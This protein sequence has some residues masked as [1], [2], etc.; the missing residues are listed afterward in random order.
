MKDGSSIEIADELVV[1][2]DPPS[3]P[4]W[5][6]DEDRPAEVKTYC[7]EIEVSPGLEINWLFPTFLR[8]PRNL[9]RP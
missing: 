2:D 6:P 9:A 8:S 1:D 3:I 7:H 5:A 4:D